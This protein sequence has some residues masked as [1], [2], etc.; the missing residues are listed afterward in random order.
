MT[1]FLKFIIFGILLTPFLATTQVIAPDFLCVSNDSLMWVPATN[2]C[3][4]F[5]AYEVYG[6]TNE[7]GPY[8]LLASITDPS[9]TVFFHVDANTQ[10]WYY[11]LLT[12]AN[13]PG[14]AVLTSDTLDNLIPI[15]EPIQNVTITPTGVEINWFPSPSPEVY[16]YVVS[17]NT[18]LGTTILD[19]VFGGVTTYTDTTADPQNVSEVY[20]VVAIDPCGNKSL[21]VDPHNTILLDIMPQNGCENGIVLNWNPYQNW[22]QGVVRYDIF[23]SINGAADILVGEVPGNS[24]TFTYLL[25]NDGENLCFK[26][27][28]VEDITLARSL[29][30]TACTMVD[31]QQPLRDIEL[32][33]ASVNANGS[34]DIEWIWDETALITNANALYFSVGND[35]IFSEPFTL[36]TPLNTINTLNVASVNVQSSAYT[37]YVNGTDECGNMITSNESINPFLTGISE[38]ESANQLAWQP[39]THNLATEISYELVKITTTGEEVIFSG[40]VSD[41]KFTDNNI[42][43]DAA[44]DNC[45]YLRVLV[46]FTLADGTVF[47]RIL[48]SNTVCLI[49]EPK[50]YVPNVFAPNSTNSQFRPFLSFNVNTNYSM[51]IYDRWGGHVFNSND[52]NN[53]WKGK[54]NGEIMPEGVYLYIIEI[55]PDGGAV[56]QLSGDVMLLH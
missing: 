44:F 34:V 18:G 16:A 30:S 12:N 36:N 19:T 52:I 39:Y 38:G 9:E 8:I 26:V 6:S 31:I 1:S 3:G 21:V 2:S 20:F 54:R 50:V 47:N 43:G 29:S 49:P 24:T 15:A 35:V 27:E 56:I 42:G 11:Y 28:A 10:I 4:A 48:H 53:G 40:N 41:V 45:Y 5:N 51:N 7:N 37:F 22:V 55:Q 14:E 33:G 17:R 32:L 46:A 13:C 23:V 25:A